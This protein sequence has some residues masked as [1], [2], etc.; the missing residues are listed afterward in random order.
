MNIAVEKYFNS[1]MMSA[2]FLSA[3]F[4]S[5]FA[6]AEL[7]I[8]AQIAPENFSTKAAILLG[9]AYVATFFVNFWIVALCYDAVK[10]FLNI[11]ILTML[12]AF[13]F[14]FVI[15]TL[16]LYITTFIFKDQ[17]STTLGIYDYFKVRILGA[18]YIF[19]FQFFVIAYAFL[20]I[21]GRPKKV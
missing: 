15:S 20:K 3:M 4:S 13:I 11:K 8:G 2:A 19:S 1:K 18:Q 10:K 21:V 6:F 17:A 5:A 14:Y 7:F 12:V 9:L 16:L